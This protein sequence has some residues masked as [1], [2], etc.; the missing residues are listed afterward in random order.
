MSALVI[1]TSIWVEYFR[2][3]SLPLI[4][5]ALQDG[6]VALP[7]LV[8]AE[9]LSGTHRPAEITALRDFLSC[10]RPHGTEM[11]HWYRVG[12]LRATLQR[13]GLHISTPDAHVAQ[14]A[15]DLHAG[16]YAHDHIFP[17]IAKTTGL[18]LIASS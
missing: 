16:L 11:S 6:T 7:V 10:L 3:Q 17:H 5:Q 2:G 1:D 14:C 15:L 4:D 18:R 13:Q 8:A 9:L 12:A